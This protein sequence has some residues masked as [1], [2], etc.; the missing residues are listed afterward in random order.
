[1]HRALAGEA[2]PDDIEAD[3][4]LRLDLAGIA[5]AFPGGLGEEIADTALNGGATGPLSFEQSPELTRPAVAEGLQ[6]WVR[7]SRGSRPD[8]LNGVLF[9]VLRLL[10]LVPVSSARPIKLQPAT[11]PKRQFVDVS[12]DKSG[13][14]FVPNFGSQAERQRRFMLCWDTDL[15]MSQLWDTAALNAPSDQPLYVLWMGMLSDASRR[16]LAKVARHRATGRVVVIDDAVI[17]RCAE[18][19]RLAWDVTMRLVLPYA[20]PNPYDPDLLA[21]T[22]EEMFYGRR[23]ER[24]SVSSLTGTSFI[25]G[26]RRLGKSAPPQVSSAAASGHR[27]S[28]AHDRGPARRCCP[29]QRSG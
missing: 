6:A 9:P 19:G 26:G 2:A 22:P 15:P 8:D 21:N 16:E 14:A 1:M 23:I 10:G 27:D 29:A 18:V 25:S 4:D 7:L 3:V 17:A 11:T 13:Y 28:R 5:T 20:S 24:E 12:G